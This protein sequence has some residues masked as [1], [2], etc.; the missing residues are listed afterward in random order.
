[1]F[2]ECNIDESKLIEI[3]SKLTE[4]NK[5]RVEQFIEQLYTQQNEDECILKEAR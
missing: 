1:M 2:K 5:G 4:R 3:F